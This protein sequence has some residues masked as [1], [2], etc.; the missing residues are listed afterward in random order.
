MA[1]NSRQEKVL[2]E[3]DRYRLD[4]AQRILMRDDNSIPL[5][6]K[7]FDVLLALVESGG[8]VVE[9]EELL[10]R[11][12]PDTFV[13]EGSLTQ[14]ISVLR[15]TLG[16]SGGGPQYI[17]T[18]SKRGYRLVA[19]VKVIEVAPEPHLPRPEPNGNPSDPAEPGP[20]PRVPSYFPT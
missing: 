12:W 14:T 10:K 19:P 15:R 13:E 1:R 7:A 2:Y 3:F 17:Q 9:K 4:P 20:I 8:R 6:P 11:V 5:T 16:Q 18:I